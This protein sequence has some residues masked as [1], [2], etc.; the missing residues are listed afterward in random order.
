LVLL[1]ENEFTFDSAEDDGAPV[2]GGVRRKFHN[3]RERQRRCLIRDLFDSLRMA[4][5]ELS[6]KD[7]VADREIL[8][9]ALVHIRELEEQSELLET[10]LAAQ[11]ERRATLLVA[12]V[13][14]GTSASLDSASVSRTSSSGG[15]SS[16]EFAAIGN[17]DADS[18]SGDSDNSNV[19]VEMENAEDYTAA[20]AAAAATL[21]GGASEPVAT[22]G[23]EVEG[24]AEDGTINPIAAAETQLAALLVMLSDSG[25]AE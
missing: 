19:D 2:P 14:S 15:E 22:A 9:E 16:T 6:R 12:A 21:A 24:T 11:Q 25:C 20:T 10:A 13:Q 4:I 17:G 3:A 8:M 5:P 1:A 23:E 7:G 18:A